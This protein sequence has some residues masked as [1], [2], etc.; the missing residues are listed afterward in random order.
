M[1]VLYITD[2]NYSC[3]DYRLVSDRNYMPLSDP[4]RVNKV[5]ETYYDVFR[6]TNA[7][8]RHTSAR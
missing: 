1:H 4:V 8:Y 5:L 2:E 6:S 7:T 3:I